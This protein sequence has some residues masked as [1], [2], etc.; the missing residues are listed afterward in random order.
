MNHIHEEG[1]WPKRIFEICRIFDHQLLKIDDI[2]NKQQVY[3]EKCDVD[4][5]DTTF[6]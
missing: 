1:K 5:V 4:I 6:F 3:K 2:R